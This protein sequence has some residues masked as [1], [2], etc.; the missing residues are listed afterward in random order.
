MSFVI[1]DFGDSIIDDRN[2]AVCQ[3]GPDVGWN[4]RAALVIFIG[5]HDGKD[6]AGR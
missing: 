4:C 3:I 5:A 6:H 2:A 1:V